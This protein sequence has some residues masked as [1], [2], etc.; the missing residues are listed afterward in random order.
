[1][2]HG[3]FVKF[4][5]WLIQ[6]D[7]LADSEVSNH[8]QEYDL[9]YHFNIVLPT[10]LA[11][12]NKRIETWGKAGTVDPF[13]DIHNVRCQHYCLNSFFQVH[14]FSKLVFQMTARFGSCRAIADD[15]AAV[16]KIADFFMK[17]QTRKSAVTVLLP[18]FPSRG[19][20]IMKQ[21]TSDLYAMLRDH[22]EARRKEIPTSDVIDVLICEGAETNEIIQVCINH[23]TATQRNLLH[24][25]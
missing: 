21:V 2:E 19:K 7:R 24:G 6:K 10:L 11:D 25:D 4:V 12:I 14:L 20:K 13:V 17:S 1:V 23:Y 22:V 15:V 18:W 8:R 5:T 16:N 9:Q 3:K